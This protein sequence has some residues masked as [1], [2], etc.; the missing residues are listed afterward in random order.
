MK[1]M[2]LLM[3]FLMVYVVIFSG[4][5]DRPDFRDG[6]FGRGANITEEQRQQMFEER[7]QKAIE[8]CQEKNEGDGCI[9]ESP[10]GD[11][12]GNCKILDENLI[13]ETERPMR[14]R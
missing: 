5:S 4:C 12:E 9:L 14:Q 8:A 3:V 6:Q 11:I 13:C 10:R 2:I 1:R 7:Q